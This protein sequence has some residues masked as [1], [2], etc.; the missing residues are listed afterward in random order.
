MNKGERKVEV[1]IIPKVPIFTTIMMIITIALLFVSYRVS[2]S[3]TEKG[4]ITR[5]SDNASMISKAITRNLDENDAILR[6]LAGILGEGDVS[7]EERVVPLLKHL[8]NLIH[9][10][11]VALI[12]PDN[13]TLSETGEVIAMQDELCYEFLQ[14][15]ERYL[16]ERMEFETG[17][18][19]A[20]RIVQ[21]GVPVKRAGETVAYLLATLDCESYKAL[22]PLAAFE[23]NA[24]YYLI[25]QNGNYIFD[26]YHRGIG[27]IYDFAD[28][29]LKDRE[30]ATV[31]EELEGILSGETGYFVFFNEETQE[32]V[33]MY[34]M[35]VEVPNWSILITIPEEYIFA[36]V[37]KS[38]KIVLFIA[39]IEIVAFVVYYIMTLRKGKRDIERNIHT[40]QLEELLEMKEKLLRAETVAK[41][42]DEERI[43]TIGQIYQT[44]HVI[45][46]VTNTYEE[47]WAV[48]SIHDAMGAVGHLSKVQERCVQYL[49]DAEYA[50]RMKE[51]LDINTVNERL[52]DKTNISTEYLSKQGV[53][54]RAVIIVRKRDESGKI[55]E[56]LYA[57]QLIDE[58]KRKELQL[59]KE[60]GNAYEQ[61]RIASEAKSNFLSSMSHDIR[62]PMNAIT[63]M[64]DIAMRHTDDPFRMQDSLRKIMASSR[65]LVSLINDILDISAI[66]S[67]K[68]TLRLSEQNIEKQFQ[69]YNDLFMQQII[70]K[71]LTYDFNIHDIISPWVLMDDIRVAQIVSNLIG[72]AVKYTPEGGKVNHEL[73]QKRSTEGQL[74]TVISVSDSGIGMT[75][76]FMEKMWDTF[77]R[78]TDTRINTVQGSGLGLSIVKELVDRMDGTI[79]VQS[80]PDKGTTFT[81]FL[82]LLPIEH[83]EKS[84][85][86]E[87][88]TTQ[89]PG[90]K[91]L[92]AEDN[93][94]NWEIIEELLSM[95]GIQSTRAE[96]GKIC[97]DLFLKSEVGQYSAIL[98]DLQM[99]VM[100]GLE[101]TRQIRASKH[102]EAKTIP[103]IAMTANAFAEDVVKCVEAGMNEHLSKP[104]DMDRVLMTLSNYIKK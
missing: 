28:F 40:A 30:N 53:W 57:T 83:V 61:A 34:H 60:L 90:V 67:G 93:D 37:Q 62:T 6:E 80:E 70:A 22:A 42:K 77:S 102:P 5:L 100:D 2:T 17:S 45:S 25:D 26:T 94:M 84:E 52:K 38:S 74:H 46:F 41:Q 11:Q 16:S 33:C 23:E 19:V 59:Q 35:P 75:K 10:E 4:C 85:T 97:L 51:F 95:H 44:L 50:T 29:K 68:L 48:P 87:L 66:E 65:Q 81:V 88:T 3:N 7:D 13:H 98:M 9:G 8:T 79:E 39:L 14:D 18:Q 69:K 89:F 104:I 54:V 31:R 64:V 91:I 103:I 47:I 56:A 36:D 55:M 43:L 76:E 49:V 82:P 92:L 86:H 58:E 99:P 24:D 78:A 73:Y 15:K 20:K 21:Q 96:D 27:S 101:S 63:G 32:W 72:N 71:S 1:D 12:L